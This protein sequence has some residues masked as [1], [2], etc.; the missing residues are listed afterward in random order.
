M[1]PTGTCIGGEEVYEFVGG[2]CGEEENENM[3]HILMVN[4]NARVDRRNEVEKIL[5]RH[6]ERF[7]HEKGIQNH[8]RLFPA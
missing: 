1:L 7:L 5:D 4:L 3:I 6:G 8:E 2:R